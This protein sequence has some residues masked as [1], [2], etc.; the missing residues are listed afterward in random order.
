MRFSTALFLLLFSA[1]LAF[2]RKADDSCRNGVGRIERSF[3]AYKLVVEPTKSEEDE[4]I[5]RAAVNGSSGNETFS[6]SEFA[7]S[8]LPISGS[9]VTN[10]GNK[11]IVLEGFSG[12]AHCCWTY[13]IVALGP[14]PGR[15]REIHNDSP[16]A[17]DR[18]SSRVVITTRDGAFNY[19]DDL[20]HAFSP[21]PT[22]FLQ[23]D[24]KILRDVSAQF[25]S[26]YDKQIS[27]V[28]QELT[29]ESVEAFRSGPTPDLKAG[30]PDTAEWMQTKAAILS[31][32]LSYLYSGRDQQAWNTLD[33][34][35]PASDRERISKLIVETRARGI[36]AQ[37]LK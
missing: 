28:R 26:E 12:G 30:G 34:M 19:F 31:L 5:C 14:H 21:M 23:L 7:I 15:V 25:V 37:T 4:P 1:T 27:G 24:G 6:I 35:W 10:D 36:L 2:A 13:W 16:L 17:F 8:V 32:V 3:G 20:P 33:E 9:S 18:V 29:A 11:S 22:I